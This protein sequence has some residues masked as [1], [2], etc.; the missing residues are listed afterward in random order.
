MNQRQLDLLEPEKSDDEPPT[1]ETFPEKQRIE[2]VDQLAVLMT[3]MVSSRLQVLP[4]VKE[5]KRDE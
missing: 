4:Y 5:G 1:W 2:V 3:R